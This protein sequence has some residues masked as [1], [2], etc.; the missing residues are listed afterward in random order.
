MN[1]NS[2]NYSF[3]ELLGDIR[4]SNVNTLAYLVALVDSKE[5]VIADLNI[6]KFILSWLHDVEEQSESAS[7]LLSRQ[8]PGQNKYFPI[9]YY[10]QT[11]VMM[12]FKWSPISSMIQQGWNPLVINREIKKRACVTGIFEAKQISSIKSHSEC[13]NPEELFWHVLAKT[14]HKAIGRN[15]LISVIAKPGWS[16]ED[17]IG[18]PNN[19]TLAEAEKADRVIWQRTPK[20]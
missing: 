12:T 3:C 9:G 6:A 4:C 13:Q 2:E 1:S 15:L 19:F 11:P 17:N 7:D 5:N 18:R 20:V 16:Y 14:A 8:D 10:P